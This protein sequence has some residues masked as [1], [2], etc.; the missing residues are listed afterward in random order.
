MVTENPNMPNEDE[1]ETALVEAARQ[2]ADDRGVYIDPLEEPTAFSAPAEEQE[3]NVGVQE[4]VE[5]LLMHPHLSA[6]QKVL[7][8]ILVWVG[9]P[10]T[11]PDI[12]EPAAMTVRSVEYAMRLLIKLGLVTEARGPDPRVEAWVLWYSL[13]RNN[14]TYKRLDGLNRPQ[15]AEALSEV[16]AEVKAEKKGK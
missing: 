6:E 11:K 10:M 5:A 4:A 16:N 3:P 1:L 15:Q 8:M 7:L 9:R 14:L 13:D 12:A 2:H